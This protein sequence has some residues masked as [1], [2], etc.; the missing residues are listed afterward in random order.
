MGQKKHGLLLGLVLGTTAA[1]VAYLSLSSS[2]KDQLLK[3]SAQKIDE[4]NAYIQTTSKKVLDTVSDKVQ[5]SKD[6]VEVYGGIAAETVGEKWQEA[7]DTVEVYGG[8]A[9]ETVGE[10]I[11]QAK[12]TVESVADDL[13]AKKDSDA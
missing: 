13:V 6:A 2:K 1:T 10:S 5:E 12:E 7:R 3:E 8:I 9:A 11:G 4:L